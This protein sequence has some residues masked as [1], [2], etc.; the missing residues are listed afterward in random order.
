[1]SS[2]LVVELD[3]HCPNQAISHS[4]EDSSKFLASLDSPRH[5]RGTS[6]ALV[7]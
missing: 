3:E 5:V 4:E 6:K 7:A 2:I 1:M